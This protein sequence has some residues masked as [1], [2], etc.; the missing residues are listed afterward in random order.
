MAPKIPKNLPVKPGECTEF[1]LHKSQQTVFNG[2]LHK[3]VDY[4]E[5]RL[6]KHIE[7]I[8]DIQQKLILKNLLEDYVS[9]EVAIAWKRGRPI[10]VKVTQA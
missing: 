2:L 4:S 3:I 8:E 7:K 1:H 9:G 5:I 6:R 10:W